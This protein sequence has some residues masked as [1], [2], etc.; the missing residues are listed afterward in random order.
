MEVGVVRVQQKLNIEV[1]VV[2]E[3][4]YKYNFLPP[5]NNRYFIL[6]VSKTVTV[7]VNNCLEDKCL[8]DPDV[9]VTSGKTLSILDI[10][11]P[12][13]SKYLLFGKTPWSFR[14]VVGIFTYRIQNTNERVIVYYRN[15]YVGHNEYGMDWVTSDES[16]DLAKI[17][18]LLKKRKVKQNRWLVR[19][20]MRKHD[21][22]SES[23][24]YSV[25]VFMSQG[26][27]SKMKVD[28]FYCG[29]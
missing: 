6:Q 18:H 8:M 2:Y 9:Y 10:I 27:H 19:D 22:E 13:E 15:P 11:A 17:K 29:N 1:R 16:A 26:E 25:R 24:Q 21:L 4:F 20:N 3:H 14:G 12:K 28:I 23:G 7:S 5:H